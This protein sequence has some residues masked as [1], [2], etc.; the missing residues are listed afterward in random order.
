MILQNIKITKLE[1][2]IKELKN[3]KFKIFKDITDIIKCDNLDN[4][5][6]DISLETHITIILKILLH[7]KPLN[8]QYNL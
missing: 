4:K 7:N 3:D 6:Y 5:L 8:I 2:E 1:N